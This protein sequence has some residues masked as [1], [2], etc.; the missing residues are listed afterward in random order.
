MLE[1]F[2]VNLDAHIFYLGIFWQNFENLLSVWVIFH[3]ILSVVPAFTHYLFKSYLFQ[4]F[5]LFQYLH[6]TCL[7]RISSSSFCCSSISLVISDSCLCRS[8]SSLCFLRWA[9]RSRSARD[10]RT[11]SLW[12]LS[13]KS[14]SSCWCDA[15]SWRQK[16]K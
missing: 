2:C 7:S 10:C 16:L 1:I 15:S 5:L 12:S 8:L 3:L 9:K 13:S 6:I 11:L 4:F 14:S